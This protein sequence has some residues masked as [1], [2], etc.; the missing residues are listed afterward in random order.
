MIRLCNRRRRRY[1]RT[2]ARHNNNIPPTTSC[3]KGASNSYTEMLSF[4]L[5]WLGCRPPA[6]LSYRVDGQT[7]P[8]VE[9]TLLQYRQR[10]EREGSIIDKDGTWSASNVLLFRSCRNMERVSR[11]LSYRSEGEPSSGPTSWTRKTKVGLGWVR[12]GGPERRLFSGSD[13]LSHRSFVRSIHGTAYYRNDEQVQAG[14]AGKQRVHCMPDEG[15]RLE[16]D[17]QVSVSQ[18]SSTRRSQRT[19]FSAF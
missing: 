9:I 17:W 7:T 16:I 13:S 6:S 8:E 3:A 2:P 15:R 4:F 11:V 10:R 5:C 12:I 19:Y 18:S 1:G 14:R